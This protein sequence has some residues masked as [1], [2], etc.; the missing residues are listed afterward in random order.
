MHVIERYYLCALNTDS[1]CVFHREIISLRVAERKS[2]CVFYL[3]QTNCICALSQRCIFC[4]IFKIKNLCMLLQKNNLCYL[5]QKISIFSLLQT[6]SLCVL[7][8]SLM[9]IVFSLNEESKF[10]CELQRE[11]FF[12][13]CVDID[14]LC[15]AR[16]LFSAHCRET[17]SPRML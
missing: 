14:S 4:M 13:P 9:W 6:N 3:L 1:F 5:L 16:R 2:L 17:A 8:L 11:Y 7:H 10:F 12:L 15:I